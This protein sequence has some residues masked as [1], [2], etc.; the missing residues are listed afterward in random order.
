M[1]N[2]TFSIIRKKLPTSCKIWSSRNL[3]SK[4]S[5]T[6]TDAAAAADANKTVFE[7]R[8]VDATTTKDWSDVVGWADLLYNEEYGY[9][10]V[11]NTCE[12]NFHWVSS[13]DVPK[14]N[15]YHSKWCEVYCEEELHTTLFVASRRNSIDDHDDENDDDDEIIG[16]VRVQSHEVLTEM[17]QKNVTSAADENYTNTNM[18]ITPDHPLP[19]ANFMLWDMLISSMY[20]RIGV[21]TALMDEVKRRAAL[22]V[23]FL[24]REQQQELNKIHSYNNGTS[25]DYHY[26]RSMVFG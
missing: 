22:I 1:R 4:R 2:L 14:R 8:R 13:N 24:T 17:L 12:E 26:T 19:T 15:V 5:S 3:V 6:V 10:A 7:V 25:F 18:E 16:A 21:A 20:R 23:S 9:D 11:P